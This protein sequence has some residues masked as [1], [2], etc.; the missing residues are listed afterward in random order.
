VAAKQ[1]KESESW[2]ACGKRAGKRAGKVTK[3]PKR[4]SA[5][6]GERG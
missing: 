2:Q 6:A 3:V 5:N 1:V 4:I